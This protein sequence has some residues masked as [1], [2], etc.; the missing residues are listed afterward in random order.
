MTLFAP[1]GT[2]AGYGGQISGEV[3]A[4]LKHA[5]WLLCDG[6]LYASADA[7]Y[8]E[9]FKLIGFS[10]GGDGT[11]M[12]A[13]PDL[14]ARFI[15]GAD[16]SKGVDPGPR[17]G[18]AVGSTQGYATARPGVP[19]ATD[20]RWADHTHAVPHIPVDDHNTALALGG[21]S[22]EEWSGSVQNTSTDG[23]HAHTISGGG[24]AETRPENIYLYYLI[25]F[26][27]TSATNKGA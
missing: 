10:F 15:R 9:L 14:R 20:K 27:A 11:K 3:L 16:H 5:G 23:A 1:V 17:T 6:S 12:F 22:A 2:V 7:D 8:A 18:P 25:R 4:V 13:V 19:F 21:G 26:C 24:D